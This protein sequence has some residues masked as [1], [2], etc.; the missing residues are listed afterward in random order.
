[1]IGPRLSI[2][3]GFAQDDEFLNGFFPPL[4]PPL[5]KAPA[6]YDAVTWVESTDNLNS[7]NITSSPFNLLQTWQCRGREARHLGLPLRILQQERAR[8]LHKAEDQGQEHQQGCLPR[9]LLSW[10]ILVKY[11][12]FKESIWICFPGIS[13]SEGLQGVL[14]SPPWPVR[15]R[16]HR[17]G[18]PT[19]FAAFTHMQVALIYIYWEIFLSCKFP[20]YG[21]CIGPRVKAGRGELSRAQEDS[22]G[23]R[24]SP[25][26]GLF[27]QHQEPNDPD[28]L[29]NADSWDSQRFKHR[30]SSQ[31]DIWKLYD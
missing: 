3:L 10:G 27:G 4:K 18:Q 21:L 31:T 24:S 2:M 28:F 26:T 14:D 5:S 25:S 1:M 20:N 9:A 16:L 8:L 29:W 13:A 7:I 15:R 30:L 11:C 6:S 19:V 22:A 12:S 23:W 17:D